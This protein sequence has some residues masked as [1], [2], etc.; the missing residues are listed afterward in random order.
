MSRWNRYRRSKETSW[1]RREIL[2]G[3]LEAHADPPRRIETVSNAVFR[4]SSADP[5]R[6]AI[7]RTV[8]FNPF[9]QETTADQHP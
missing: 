5:P 2:L 9:P 1:A 6:A 4:P 8:I 7:L 3:L